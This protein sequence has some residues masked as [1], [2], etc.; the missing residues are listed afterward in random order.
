MYF[1][2]NAGRARWEGPGAGGS[3][4]AAGLLSPLLLRFAGRRRRRVARRS[5]SLG[6]PPLARA[7]GQLAPLHLHQQHAGL[8]QVVDLP[9]VGGRRRCWE[10]ALGPGAGVGRGCAL[11]PASPPHPA[12][13]S[14]PCPRHRRGRA[15]PSPPGS[16]SPTPQTWS[17][18]AGP[19]APCSRR[20]LRAGLDARAPHATLRR[21]AP[22]RRDQRLGPAPDRPTCP[23]ACAPGGCA[24]A[25]GLV[26][27]RRTPTP[28]NRPPV[29]SLLK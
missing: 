20:C 15:P 1:Y 23:P 3:R 8:H 29:L 6:A 5:R 21:A 4:R 26:L 2:Y 18:A 9:C 14:R 22:Q 13:P 10:P 19:T 28:Q 17:R 12:S 7:P 24:P 25:A 11:G 16:L 27:A